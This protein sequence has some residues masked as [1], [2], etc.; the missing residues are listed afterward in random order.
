[1]ETNICST[2]AS[3]DV[4]VSCILQSKNFP[5]G[6]MDAYPNRTPY[7]RRRPFQQLFQN[8]FYG[9]GYGQRQGPHR[10]QQRPQFDTNA[11]G[12]WPS[13]F[14]QDDNDEARYNNAHARRAPVQNRPKQQNRG[15][16]RTPREPM[17]NRKPFYCEAWQNT[18][19]RR[20]ELERRDLEEIQAKFTALEMEDAFQRLESAR[21]QQ[22]EFMQ[23]AHHAEKFFSAF[24]DKLKKAEEKQSAYRSDEAKR[25]IYEAS[26]EWEQ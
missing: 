10:P 16:E 22:Q 6:V 14:V 18:P 12:R 21:K 2:V 4:R 26:D 1:M 11:R 5:F 13:G 7:G 9:Q 8:E 3:S 25:L 15:H 19:A 17:S 24:K 20:A 23:Y